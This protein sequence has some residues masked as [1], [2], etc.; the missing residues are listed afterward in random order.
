MLCKRGG[1]MT[2]KAIICLG[3]FLTNIQLR[4]PY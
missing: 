4:T 1:F 2:T 3:D